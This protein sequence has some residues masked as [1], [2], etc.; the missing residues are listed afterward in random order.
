LQTPFQSIVSFSQS[1]GEVF[2]SLKMFKTLQN[3]FFQPSH[4]APIE[5]ST[6][7]STSSTQGHEIGIVTAEKVSQPNSK[8][9]A[10]AVEQTVNEERP[11]EAAQNGVTQAEAITLTWTK[12]SLGCAYVL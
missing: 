7:G 5:A 2:T 1:I 8:V 10:A 9:P 4:S 6:E 12:T 11:N 3:K